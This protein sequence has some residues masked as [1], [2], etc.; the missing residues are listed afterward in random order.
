[1]IGAHGSKTADHASRN[2][3]QSYKT[4]FSLKSQDL[5][6]EINPNQKMFYD[7]LVGFKLPVPRRLASQM[8]RDTIDELRKALNRIRE[9]N[10]QMKIRLN[11]YRTQVE[12][13]ESMEGGWYE[14]AQFMQ[15]LLADPIYQSDVEMLD[16]E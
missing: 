9:E 4:I 12:I 15:T 5:T 8:P 6:L 7:E 2:N 11:R 14:H 10:N 13:R 1:M 16:E 3:E